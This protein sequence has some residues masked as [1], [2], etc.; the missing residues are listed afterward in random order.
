MGILNITPDSFYDGGKYR[1]ID[2]IEK[3][4]S[5]MLTGG[6][7]WIDIGAVSTR[8]QSNTSDYKTEKERLE[9]VL[10]LLMRKFPDAL[11]SVDTFRAEIAKMAVEKYGA[12]MINDIS[13][14]EMD[15]EM[16]KT[17]GKLKVPYIAM[18]MR[19]TPAI[20][21]S[22]ENTNYTDICNEIIQY[23]AVKKQKLYEEGIKDVIIDPGFGFSKTISQN[24]ILLK[25]LAKFKILD[26]P[27][28]V[29]ISRKSMI[30]KT[31]ACSPEQA[32]SGTLAAN[33][34]AIVN[35]ADILRVHDVKETSEII[36]IF[37][38]YS[39]S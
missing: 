5:E 9:P 34:L 35:G 24:F 14:G 16:I 17:A 20:M 6:A 31:L 12:C 25:N 28:I 11:V 2:D 32:L 33:M 21:Q 30:Y 36:K 29:G 10:D 3:A 19:G 1:N 38:Q 13:A 15:N 18:H 4:V 22:K 39:I 26:C 8:P 37:K 7:K 23:L 27:I